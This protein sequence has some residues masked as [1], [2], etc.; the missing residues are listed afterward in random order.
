MSKCHSTQ[1]GHNILYHV[2]ALLSGSHGVIYAFCHRAG[3]RFCSS[4]PGQQI[5]PSVLGE[6]CLE[7]FQG[8]T[9]PS[10][11]ETPSQWS[12]DHC[13]NA[14]QYWGP[15]GLYWVRKDKTRCLGW[16][17][18]GDKEAEREGWIFPLSRAGEIFSLIWWSF[19][20]QMLSICL[21][22]KGEGAALHTLK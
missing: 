2:E 12:P 16:G 6:E 17:R 18:E 14:S 5:P 21:C 15:L 20:F 22:I 1:D 10:Y 11:A 19:K 9:V 8:V 3:R 13:T 4:S 7:G